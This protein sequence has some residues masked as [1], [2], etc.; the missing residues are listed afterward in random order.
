MRTGSSVW[1]SNFSFLV[2]V[3][4]RLINVV[5]AKLPFDS[6]PM[7]ESIGTN[8]EPIRLKTRSFFSS[9]L[10][11]AAGDRASVFVSE[12]NE[13]PPKSLT[14]MSLLI[15]VAFTS[16]SNLLNLSAIVWRRKKTQS[17]NLSYGSIETN[18]FSLAFNNFQRSNRE[19][20]S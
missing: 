15:K 7:V 4:R 10:G 18:L 5:F 14:M 20:H 12:G 13:S 16:V 17:E 9:Q 11:S 3:R 8:W 19:H 2:G 1:Y 6:A